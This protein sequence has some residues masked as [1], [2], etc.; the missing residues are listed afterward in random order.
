M[1]GGS[2]ESMLTIHNNYMVFTM[3]LALA[4]FTCTMQEI[5][6]EPSVLNGTSIKV[7]YVM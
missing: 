5:A 1:F 6:R 7:T 2:H 3:L 4:S